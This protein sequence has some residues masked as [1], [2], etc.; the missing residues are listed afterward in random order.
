MSDSIALAGS[1][2]L[3]SQGGG[4]GPA[5]GTLNLSFTSYP[6]TK[7]AAASFNASKQVNSPISFATL[8]G[9]GAAESVTQGTLLFLSTTS[10]MDIEIT[11]ATSGPDNVAVIPV[12]GT[13]IIEFPVNKYLKGLRAQGVGIVSYLATGNQ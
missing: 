7:P 4:C 6:P 8:D 11:T 12:Q 5:I 1:I 10:P 3:G 2:V 9:I 13:L